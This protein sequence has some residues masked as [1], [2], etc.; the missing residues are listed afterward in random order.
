[1][2]NLIHP[3]IRTYPVDHYQGSVAEFPTDPQEYLKVEIFAVEAGVNWTTDLGATDVAEIVSKSLS[4]LAEVEVW[5]PTGIDTFSSHD[6]D[7]ITGSILSSETI[8]LTFGVDPDALA[9]GGLAVAWRICNDNSAP[10]HQLGI[11]Q[12]L[13]NLTLTRSLIQQTATYS[14]KNNPDLLDQILGTLEI[15]HPES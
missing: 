13:E 15:P 1:M 12:N 6:L 4:V 9:L 14:I 8:R 5:H 3:N 11:L 2:P 10:P 7:S